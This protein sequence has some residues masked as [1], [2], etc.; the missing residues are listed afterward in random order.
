MSMMWL[1]SLAFAGSYDRFVEQVSADARAWAEPGPTSS[2]DAQTTWRGVWEQAGDYAEYE[3]D[4]AKRRGDA[5]VRRALRRTWDPSLTQPRTMNAVCA[6]L[7]W[8]E[9]S[10]DPVI[11]RVDTSTCKLLKE[12]K[13][14]IPDFTRSATQGSPRN[15]APAFAGWLETDDGL[16]STYPLR[17][18]ARSA[19]LL[20]WA[21]GDPIT[22]AAATGRLGWDLTLGGDP[23]VTMSGLA[24]L[25]DTHDVL[26]GYALES[27]EQELARI[28]DIA[29]DLPM[30]VDLLQ[31]ARVAYLSSITMMLRAVDES[32]PLIQHG[33][34]ASRHAPLGSL[35]D[36][37][38]MKVP[39]KQFL[40]GPHREAWEQAFEQV[41][42]AAFEQRQQAL[43]ALAKDLEESGGPVAA[44]VGAAASAEIESL[45]RWDLKIMVRRQ[46]SCLIEAGSR[47]A[48]GQ[49][50]P[51]CPLGL[52][53]REDG[54]YT[55][56]DPEA[57]NL[58]GRWT[59]AFWMP[60]VEAPE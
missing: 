41:Q 20:G 47:Q 37:S 50:L 28:A 22:P 5:G 19:L 13:A 23:S 42:I 46:E 40:K 9:T 27:D 25:D 44:L 21:D 56:L 51:S 60:K 32:S 52:E 6:E 38:G 49:P 17:S 31:L 16:R 35:G 45:G 26:K 4:G 58:K 53:Q 59:E 14:L 36:L 11:A 3:K 43:G 39:I 12:H 57:L 8:P 10:D 29:R 15:P 55:P 33:T 54:L 34:V 18:V 7:G 24:T 1:L 30:D 48:L 2:P